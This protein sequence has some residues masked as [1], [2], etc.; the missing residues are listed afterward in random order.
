VLGSCVAG[1]PRLRQPTIT[2]DELFRRTQEIMDAT[3]PGIPE[4]W[5]KYFAEDAMY[6][7]EK[8]GRWTRQLF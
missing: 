2:H 6:F 5:K 4:P 3:A 8:G 7:D 1:L